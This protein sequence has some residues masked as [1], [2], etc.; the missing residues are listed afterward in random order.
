M[1]SKALSTDADWPLPVLEDLPPE[2]F[3]TP[4][5]AELEATA[6]KLEATAAELE[7]MVAELAVPATPPV[8]YDSHDIDCPEAICLMACNVRAACIT[9][10][11]WSRS[12]TTYFIYD[13]PLNAYQCVC[14]YA[15]PCRCS[16]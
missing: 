16:T 15:P 11:V 7:A 5:A 2:G 4:A 9:S 3:C 12:F 14:R 6:A 8:I 10:Q 13:I 1:G